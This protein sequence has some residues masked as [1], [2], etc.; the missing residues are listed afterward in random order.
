MEHTTIDFL[1]SKKPKLLRSRFEKDRYPSA[2]QIM[3]DFSSVLA[4][5]APLSQS[6]SVGIA[7]MRATAVQPSAL[8]AATPCGSPAQRAYPPGG[9]YAPRALAPLGAKLGRLPRV[10][11]AICRAR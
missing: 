4:N 1:V 5:V 11:R 3:V 8:V 7:F 6:S 9:G 2:H 10:Y